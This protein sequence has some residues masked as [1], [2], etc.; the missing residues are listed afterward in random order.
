M[1]CSISHLCSSLILLMRV[2]FF[3]YL[4][5]IH[6][7]LDLYQSISYFVFASVI[8]IEF[9]ILNSTCSLLVYREAIAFCI[10]ILCPMEVP[11]G[12]AA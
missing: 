12:I 1:G 7:L 5:L 6:I 3:P 8:G 11:G 2:F 4:A 9:L 10:L